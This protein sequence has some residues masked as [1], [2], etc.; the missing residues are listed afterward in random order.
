MSNSSKDVLANEISNEIINVWNSAGI[1]TLELSYVTKNIIKRLIERN[2]K[3]ISKKTQK[4]SVTL[5]HSQP[6]D[7]CII[8]RCRCFVRAKREEDIGK[9][10][11]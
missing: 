11:I 3:Y 9:L 1:P 6:K 4:K 2:T 8:S 5:G 10:Y 7:C